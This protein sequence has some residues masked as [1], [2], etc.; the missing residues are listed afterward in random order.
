MTREDRLGPRKRPSQE[1]SRKTMETILDAAVRVFAELGFT[2]GTT[3]HIA[4]SAGISVGSLYQYFPNK[5]AILVG[6]MERHLADGLTHLEP[7]M[8]EDK[9]RGLTPKELIRGMLDAVATDQLIDSRLHRVLLEAALR[10]PAVLQQVEDVAERVIGAI[11]AA[12]AA[13]G[14]TRVKD[15]AL[16]ARVVCLAGISLTHALALLESE[17]IDSDRYLDEVADLLSRYLYP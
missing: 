6:L 1:R 12:L 17:E 5:D 11:E 7:W 13:A 8:A 9:H 4:R 14:E 2:G 16:A 3:N 10:S 15:L